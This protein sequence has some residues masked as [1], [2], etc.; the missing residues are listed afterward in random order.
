MKIS[1]YFPGL[2]MLFT[3]SIVAKL[4]AGYLPQ[5]LGDVFVAVLLGILINNLYSYDADKFDPGISLGLKKILKIA[6]ILLGAGISFQEMLSVGGRGL[7]AVLIIISGAFLLT[8]LLGSLMGIDFRQKLLIAAG[9]SICGNTAVVTSAPI[10]EAE[11]EDIFLAVG[12]VTI[13]GVIAVFVYPLLGNFVALSDEVFGAWAGTAINDTSQVVAAGFIYSDAAGR[14]ATIIKLTR[15]VLMAPIILLVSFI[16]A[17][18]RN[19]SGDEKGG[20]SI[21]EVFPTFILGF[22]LLAVFNSLR[23]IPADL[24]NFLDE[25]AGFLILLA[26]S[27]IGLQVELDDIRKIGKRPLLTGFAVAIFMAAVSLLINLTLF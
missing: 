24:A 22:L 12:I 27:G 23:L 25:A 21:R 10:I 11:E 7:I 26:L 4:I 9:L 16:Y 5:F 14:V 8:F 1:R 20:F 3:I 2:F 18:R 19:D 13:F 15:N 17:R 6:I